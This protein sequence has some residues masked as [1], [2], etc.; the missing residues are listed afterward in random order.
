MSRINYLRNLKRDIF[1]YYMKNLSILEPYILLCICQAKCSNSVSLSQSTLLKIKSFSSNRVVCWVHKN[2]SFTLC[3]VSESERVCVCVCVDGRRPLY[4]PAIKPCEKW[5][6]DVHLQ[7]FK[8]PHPYI[9]SMTALCYIK[10]YIYNAGVELRPITQTWICC[11][12]NKIICQPF[13][14][15]TRPILH[16]IPQYTVSEVCNVTVDEKLKISQ[17]WPSYFQPSS[18]WWCEVHQC[19]YHW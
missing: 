2:L 14:G 12:T 4:A 1:F 15:T 16:N 18:F 3:S 6:Q 11:Q 19:C 7:P 8:V 13:W 9:N 17:I 5:Q 10:L